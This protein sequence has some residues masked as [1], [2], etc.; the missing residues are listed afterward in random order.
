ME[1][2]SFLAALGLAPLA[3]LIPSDPTPAKRRV[4]KLKSRRPGRFTPCWYIEVV[5]K[6]PEWVMKEYGIK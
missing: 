4:I 1:R 5:E 2:R 3:L 6:T